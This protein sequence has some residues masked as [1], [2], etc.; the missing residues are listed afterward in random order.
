[1]L[2]GVLISTVNFFGA[3]LN[4]GTDDFLSSMGDNDEEEG[5][6]LEA[7]GVGKGVGNDFPHLPVL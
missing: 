2:R 1:M 7:E 6:T 4:V 5:D 3:A